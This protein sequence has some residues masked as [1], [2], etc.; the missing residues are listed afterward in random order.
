MEKSKVHAE[1]EMERRMDD[2][3][4]NGNRNEGNC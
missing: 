1:I 2:G 3:T 4:K